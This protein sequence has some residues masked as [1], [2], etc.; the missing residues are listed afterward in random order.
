MTVLASGSSGNAALVECRG[1]GVLLDCG[2]GPRELT[3]RLQAV[4]ANFNTI[5]ACVLTHT[6]TDHWNKFALERLRQF[7]IPLFAH[8]D[9]HKYLASTEQHAALAKEGLIRN[10]AADSSVPLTPELNLRAVEVSHDSTPTFALR[11]DS[12]QWSIGLASD[13]GCVANSL[14]DLFHG[15]QVL[16]LE[17]NHDEEMQRRSQRPRALVARCLSDY[18]HLSNKQAAA[19]VQAFAEA[20]EPGELKAVIQLHLSRECNTA[21]LAH[22]AGLKA[23]KFA[24]CPAKLITAS[25]F[26]PTES[27]LLVP[28]AN[29]VP[30]GPA[31]RLRR[32]VQPVLPGLE[33]AGAK[34]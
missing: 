31:P 26:T 12:P 24:N 18:G 4:G 9:H 20:S 27:V 1:A 13:L 25:Q 15:V 14:F 6:H 30:S 22:A 19:A 29:R 11:I 23:L 17:F 8:P 34:N 7:K 2:Y 10:Y 3:A 21:E 16:A 33:L 28:Q 32:T 5:R